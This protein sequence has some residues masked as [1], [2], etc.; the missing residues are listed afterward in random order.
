M[1]PLL[2][3]GH[4]C[5]VSLCNPLSGQISS[6]AKSYSVKQPTKGLGRSAL[7]AEWL[8]LD[9]VTDSVTVTESRAV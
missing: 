1:Q 2:R 8:S 9:S 5:M 3:S 6:F 4:V 7:A